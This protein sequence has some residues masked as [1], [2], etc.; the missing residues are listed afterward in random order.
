MEDFE[1]SIKIAVYKPN[2]EFVRQL[3][4]TTLSEDT[5]MML[6][7]DVA[8]ELESGKRLVVGVAV[9]L[10]SRLFRVYNIYSIN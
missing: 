5:L 7:E 6:L 4:N 1:I 3:D 10:Y 9:L 2:G 8:S